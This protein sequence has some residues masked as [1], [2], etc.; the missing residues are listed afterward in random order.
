MRLDQWPITR[1]IRRPSVSTSHA[2]WCSMKRQNGTRTSTRL[3][4][5]S[6]LTMWQL[7]IQRW[8]ARTMEAC[9][10]P[11]SRSGCGV[12]CFCT[13]LCIT[14]RGQASLGPVVTLASPPTGAE[15][16]L[17]A[18]HN[19]EGHCGSVPYIT[20]TMLGQHSGSCNTNTR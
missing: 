11:Y 10:I 16:R 15:T 3:T 4:T 18:D 20:S 9:D 8:C 1:M 13:A 17:D 19:D 12:P 14:S 5:S 6:S 2:M 7:I